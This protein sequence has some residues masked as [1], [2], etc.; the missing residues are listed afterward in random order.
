MGI[1]TYLWSCRSW[2]SSW[3][4]GGREG[5]EGA[6]QGRSKDEREGRR[7]RRRT[8]KEGE[9]GQEEE[10]WRSFLY[11]IVLKSLGSEETR[12]EGATPHTI[13]L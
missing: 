11:I 2:H 7:A 6:S 5:Q 13:G 3:L 8:G 9:E 4:E 1:T 10:P 12:R